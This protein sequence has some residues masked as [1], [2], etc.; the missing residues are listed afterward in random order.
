MTKVWKN[1]MITG[2][3]A[4]VGILLVL[5]LGVRPVYGAEV[6]EQLTCYAERACTNNSTVTCKVEGPNCSA[7]VTD[8]GVTCTGFMED[9]RWG[10]TDKQCP[11]R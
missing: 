5:I 2:L 3:L 7:A 10:S 1:I 11:K 4:V 9:G 6:T 8:T